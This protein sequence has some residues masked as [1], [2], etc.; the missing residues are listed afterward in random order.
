MIEF[1]LLVANCLSYVPDKGTVGASGDLGPLSHL[2]LGLMGEGRMWSP[3]TG[4]TSAWEVC[5][6][7]GKLLLLLI[8]LVCEGSQCTRIEAYNVETKRSQLNER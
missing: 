1:T 8:L 6:L 5:L 3:E 7:G 4:W 2:A